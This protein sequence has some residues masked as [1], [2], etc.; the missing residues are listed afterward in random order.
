MNTGALARKTAKETVEN[1]VKN[2][3][4]PLFLCFYMFPVCY[5]LYILYFHKE[6][7]AA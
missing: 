2:E 1:A 5:T 3:Q 6:A 7:S 4:V